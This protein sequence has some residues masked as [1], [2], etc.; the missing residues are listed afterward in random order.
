MSNLL[1]FWTYATKYT[2]RSLSIFIDYEDKVAVCE[3]KDNLCKDKGDLCKDED[4]GFKVEMSLCESEV[5]L[6]EVQTHLCD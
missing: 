5:L 2:L 3:D 1:R 6:Y 4:Y